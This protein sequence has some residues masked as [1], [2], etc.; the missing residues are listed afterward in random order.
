MSGNEKSALL[1][2]ALLPLAFFSKSCAA[3][4][5][6]LASE[7][8][9]P[10]GYRRVPALPKS[11]GAY[12]RSLP[13]YPA[14]RRVHL[15]NGRLKD[16]QD[17]HHRVVRLDV[18]RRDLQQCADAVM[19]LR[20]EYLFGIAKHSAISFRFTSGDAFP[21]AKWAAG[22]RPQVRG[23][24]VRFLRQGRAEPM[25]RRSSLRRYLDVVFTYAG[26]A[27][28][29]RELVPSRSCR[30]VRAGDVFI[31]GGFPGHAVLVVDV[32]QGPTEAGGLADRVFLLAQSYMPAQE[33]HVLVNP[34]DKDLSPWYRVE[35]S[36]TLA[37]PEWDFRT[38][39][40][41]CALRRWP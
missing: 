20:A 29:E 39:A 14:G 6:T 5:E 17:A 27:S 2:A 18:G 8:S 23:N 32:A 28:L 1:V 37:T 7:I 25:T 41:H 40:A 10:R 36:G 38:D 12:L 22:W 19:R 34:N 3:S 31:Q 24:H 30:D 4:A 33:I 35:K 26:S 9:P 16:R 21:Y 11:F 15:F 13:L